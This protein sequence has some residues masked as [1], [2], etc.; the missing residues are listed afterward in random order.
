MNKPQALTFLADSILRT[1][2]P[3]NKMTLTAISVALKDDCPEAAEAAERAC[4]LLC[5]AERQQL[6][7]SRILEDA[8]R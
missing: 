2:G 4:A 8:T 5:E 1:T 7:L 3:Q 6:T